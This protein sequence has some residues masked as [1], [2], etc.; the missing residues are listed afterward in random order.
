MQDQLKQ[1]ASRASENGLVI[2]GKM[3]LAQQDGFD[4]R[5]KSIA[6]LSPDPKSFW[7]LFSISEHANDGL[8]DPIDR[9]SG[10]TILK[11]ANEVEGMAIFPFEGPPYYPFST[12]AQ[13]AGSA[14]QSPSGLLVHAEYGLWISFR[15]AVALEVSIDAPTDLAS[16]C[17]A[18]PRPCLQVCPVNALGEDGYDYQSC[19]EHV[20]SIDGTDCAEQGCLARRACPIGQDHAP[21][22]QQIQCHMKA[23][24]G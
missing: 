2:S 20:R 18:C 24:S 1:L 16:P 8:T 11:I 15:G 19:R 23:F 17:I 21:P 14:W 13:R 10:S 4:D 12:W 22:N 9:W 6:L 7:P 5:Y 3:A